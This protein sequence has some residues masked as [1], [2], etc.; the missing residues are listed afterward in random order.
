MSD[1]LI[2]RG[3]SILLLT[4]VGISCGLVDDSRTEDNKYIYHTF[5]D[6]G[7]ET[8]CLAHYD[9]NG[10]G[11]LSR[12]EAQRVVRLDCASSGIT[13][14]VDLREFTNLRELDCRDNALTTLDVRYLP[15]LERLDCS[16]NGLTWLDVGGL[17]GLTWLDCSDNALTQLD[18]ASNP[19]LTW[20]DCRSNGLVTLDVSPCAPTLEADCRS[21]PQLERVYYGSLSQ[22]I[23]TDGPTRLEA[24]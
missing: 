20:L 6:K 19:S 4:A 24:R 17:R 23:R 11:R 5:Y 15:R 2:H 22:Q 12:Y 3:L 1:R 8:F 14:L 18:L 16:G 7:F 13:S 10:D 9:L 21:N